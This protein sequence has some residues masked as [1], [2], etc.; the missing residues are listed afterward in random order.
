[1]TSSQQTPPFNKSKDFHVTPDKLDED[2]SFT[3]RW[4]WEK[5]VHQDWLDKL[6][7]DFPKVLNV[8]EGTKSS[9]GCDMAAYLCYMGVRLLEMWENFKKYWFNIFTL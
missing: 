2:A 4:K 7:D 9:Y 8:I 6:S 5:D 1:M 3:N